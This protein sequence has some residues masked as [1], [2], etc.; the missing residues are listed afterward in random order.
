MLSVGAMGTQVIGTPD[1][2]GTEY[3]E[4]GF[5]AH[6]FETRPVTARTGLFPVIGVRRFPLQQLSQSAGPCAMH[7]GTDH[8][9][10]TLQI[11]L[12]GGPAFAENDAKQLLYFA[13]DFFADRL[14]RFFSWADTALSVTG[15]SWQIRVL[16]STNC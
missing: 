14:G 7:R 5:G 1:L 8:G 15:R 16:T 3:R 13:G 12:A 11:E 2:Y 4:K 10:D 9:L 6:L